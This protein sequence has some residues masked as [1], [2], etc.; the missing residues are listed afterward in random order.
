MQEAIMRSFMLIAVSAIAL[1]GCN[2]GNVDQTGQDAHALG[3]DVSNATR[4]AVANP[5]W[6]R[7]GSD[8]N[9]LGHDVSQDVKT[10]ASAT[11]A[12]ADK[13]AQD[14]KS[15]PDNAQKQPASNG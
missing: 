4:T 3:S 5:A 10:S 11:K 15:A 9:R 6:G 12:T 13:V 14:I 8:L 1:C 2:K 7:A